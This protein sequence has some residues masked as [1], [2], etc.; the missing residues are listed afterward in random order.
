MS[1][2]AVQTETDRGVNRDGTPASGTGAPL[3]ANGSSNAASNAALNAAL[4]ADVTA[5]D[6]S[7]DARLFQALRSDG[8]SAWLRRAAIA[9]LTVSRS[10]TRP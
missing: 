3:A 8:D 9:A 2:P 5:E 1:T 7:D 4:N 10:P 6:K